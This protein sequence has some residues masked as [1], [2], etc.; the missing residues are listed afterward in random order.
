MDL[1]MP[2]CGGIEATGMIREYEAETGV[3]Q[4]PIIALTAHAMIGK[5]RSRV[6]IRLRKQALLTL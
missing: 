1:S 3:P 4:T 6:T 5:F 2:V